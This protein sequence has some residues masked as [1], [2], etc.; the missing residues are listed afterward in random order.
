MGNWVTAV[1]TTDR[2]NI[3]DNVVLVGLV[4][5]EPTVEAQIGRSGNPY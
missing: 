4:L 5:M 1:K 3:G 2:D